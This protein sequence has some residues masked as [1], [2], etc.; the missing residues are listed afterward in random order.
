MLE[1]LYNPTSAC[2]NDMSKEERMESFEKRGRSLN[3]PP[4][5]DAFMLVSCFFCRSVAA[6]QEIAV[7]S[8]TENGPA[9]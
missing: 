6:S 7:V 3:K 8:I 2:E 9:C 5:S 4:L 1:K